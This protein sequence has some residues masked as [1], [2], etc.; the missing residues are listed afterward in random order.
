MS[1]AP[2]GEDF[3]P[4]EW[5]PEYGGRIFEFDGFISHRRGDGAA[6]L[7]R[8]LRALG[9]ETW[10]DGDADI[11]RRRVQ[12]TVATA[13]RHSRYLVAHVTPHY[14]ESPWTQAE[15]TLAARGG[16]A[17]GC[18]RI[19]VYHVTGDVPAMPELAGVPRFGPETLVDL[20][21]FLIGANALPRGAML[22]PLY[23]RSPSEWH[24]RLLTRAIRRVR[25]ADPGHGSCLHLH[26]TCAL[27]LMERA[28]A[29]GQPI[30]TL[31]PLTWTVA[32]PSAGEWARMRRDVLRALRST[33]LF[34]LRSPE[35]GERACA[36]DILAA[37]AKH[38]NDPAAARG[39][40]RGAKREEH[41]WILAR[42]APALEHPVR[43]LAHE[44]SLLKHRVLGPKGQIPLARL[45]SP[46]VR[47]RL[48]M[49]RPFDE[50]L[51]PPVHRFML[52]RGSILV[53]LEEM[54]AGSG[55]GSS[56]ELENELRALD[57]TIF[58]MLWKGEAAPGAAEDALTLFEAIVDV[59]RAHGGY[60]LSGVADVALSYFL[61]QA[62]LLAGGCDA[63]RAERLLGGACAI[64]LASVPGDF[65]FREE[66][67]AIARNV[68]GFRAYVTGSRFAPGTRRDAVPAFEAFARRA[69]Y[70]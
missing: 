38:A 11:R 29:G 1:H 5:T 24:R 4:E 6:I 18:D 16:Q 28:V 44:M 70:L 53:M 39:L 49:E 32:R 3:L 51:L 7:Q 17:A 69:P 26:G 9:A 33:A 12:D 13:L 41:E 22:T 42:I 37:L 62:I 59:S 47:L 67:E 36:F 2:P 48:E 65:F 61:P 54:Q 66:L 64:L 8:Q 14:G 63:Q 15:L 56:W 10:H 23:K 57:E 31:E 40:R 25:E 19:V 68:E 34:F 43:L 35:T 58:P 27:D 45:V 50:A 21:R 30:E 46:I 20:A 55:P 52:A 60:P